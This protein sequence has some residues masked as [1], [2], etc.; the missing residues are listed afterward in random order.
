MSGKLTKVQV[1]DLKPDIKKAF[2]VF[3]LDH[4]GQI[5]GNEFEKVLV[6][7]NESPEWTDKM[8][9]ERIKE[10]ANTFV[11]AADTNADGKV[12]FDEFFQFLTA[13]LSK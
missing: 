10:L 9:P 2:D 5:D 13:N 3:D 6:Q 1:E 8:T 12:N 11:K 4:S 7:I